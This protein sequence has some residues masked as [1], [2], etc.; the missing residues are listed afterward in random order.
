MKPIL[1]T[2][3]GFSREAYFI[4]TTDEFLYICS[5]L[6]GFWLSHIGKNDWAKDMKCDVLFR[7]AYTVTDNPT[8]NL[9]KVEWIYDFPLIDSDRES[10]YYI[11]QFFEI[12]LQNNQL[13]LTKRV[14][15]CI[16]SVRGH[17]PFDIISR[18]VSF[19][20]NERFER[21]ERIRLLVSPLIQ[22]H[23]PYRKKV[24]E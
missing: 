17:L 4:R 12:Y 23:L 8:P 7:E 13:N 16:Q 10:I 22:Q 24:S 15:I 2:A 19:V 3:H 21:N 18:L 5:P 9:D 14:E 6:C 1:L 20:V 11:S